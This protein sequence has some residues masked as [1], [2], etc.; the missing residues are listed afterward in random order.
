MDVSDRRIARSQDNIGTS[1][2]QITS[3][4]FTDLDHFRE[5]FRFRGHEMIQLNSGYLEG[6][7]FL[8]KLSDLYF[9]YHWSNQG[10]HFFG[11]AN[12]TDRKIFNIVCF[13]NGGECF[14]FRHPIE[15]QRTL[16]GFNSMGADFV[17]NR[18]GLMMQIGISL[19]IFHTYAEQLQRYDLDERFWRQNNV[20][21]LPTGMAEIK[22]YLQQIFWLAVYKPSWLHQPHIEQLIADDFIPLFMSQIPIK[23][24]SKSFFKPSRQS[25]LISRAEQ[26][27]LNYLDK[28]LTLKQLAEDLES[29]S[30]A[31]SRGFQYFF[32][33]SPMRYL[34]VRRLHA[35]RQHLKVNES[36]GCT[37][38]TL[39]SQFGFY[40]PNHF[41]KDYKT[42]FGELPSQTLAKPYRS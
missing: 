8:I 37:I 27:I 18:G 12:S 10:I 14:S 4:T 26:K 7:F 23:R 6:G 40:H 42:M 11:D 39:A 2:L 22:N 17:A 1:N 19:K 34:K 24:N 15:P 20:N 9:A 38:A 31:L 29:S 16:F 30:S 28:P 5:F 25:P 41:T 32:G 35:I 13:E 36:E 3:K 33:I 21:L